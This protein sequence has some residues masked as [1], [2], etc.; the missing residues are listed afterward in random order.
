MDILEYDSVDAAIRGCFG[1]DVKVLRK[2]RVGGGDINDSGCLSLS[3]GQKVFIKENTVKNSGFFEAESYGIGLISSFG[4]IGTPKLFCRGID[5]RSQISFLMMEMIEPAARI[6]DFWEVFG[7]ELAL[8][9]RSDTEKILAHGAFGLELDNYIGAGYQINTPKSSWTGFFRECRLE[10]QIKRAE[11]YF[12][13][14]LLS[15]LIRLLDR[16]EELLA[17]PVKPALLHG[18]LWSGNYI[19]GSD[20]KAWLI[21]P[22]VYVG[23][24]EADLAMTELFGRFHGDFY[25]AYNETNPLQEGYTERRDLYNLYHLLNHLNL[26][27][28]SYLPAVTGIIRYYGGD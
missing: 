1:E 15:A 4:V 9:H 27:G 24:P 8:L 17:E 3:S 13:R 14:S 7:R 28:S 10:P 18:D 19:I 16:L 25:R 6:R 21:D 11:R 12:D 2:S 23:H 22:A 26:F 20:G 5:Q